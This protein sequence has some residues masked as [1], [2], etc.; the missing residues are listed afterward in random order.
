LP[1][2]TN[3]HRSEQKGPYLP[4]NQLPTFL[5]VGQRTCGNGFINQKEN[6]Q[7]GRLCNRRMEKN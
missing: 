4:E 3:L 6:S 7:V 1:K 2:S 5:Q